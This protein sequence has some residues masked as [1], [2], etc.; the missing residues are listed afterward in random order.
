MSSAPTILTVVKLK[1]EMRLEKERII[2]NSRRDADLEYTMLKKDPKMYV[3]EERD[4][5]WRGSFDKW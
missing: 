1:S 4:V 5:G 3:R 2:L